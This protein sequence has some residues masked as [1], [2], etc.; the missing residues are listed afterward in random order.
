MQVK[1][2]SLGTEV[3]EKK[4]GKSPLPRI[5]SRETENDAKDQPVKNGPGVGEN[6]FFPF[7]SFSFC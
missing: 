1:G 3:S 7:N 5:F 6:V 4:W 2:A